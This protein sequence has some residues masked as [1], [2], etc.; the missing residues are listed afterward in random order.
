MSNFES[1][2]I[3]GKNLYIG[4]YL[5]SLNLNVLLQHNITHVLVCGTELSCKF[6]DRITYKHLKIED[7]STYPIKEH[8]EEAYL[9]IFK[10]TQKGRVLVHC[11]Q[12]ISRS[13][14]IVISYFMK[15]QRLKFQK[16]FDV[17][18]KRHPQ[19]KPN[20]GFRKQ[21]IE[22]EKDIGLGGCMNCIF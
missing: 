21:L 16:A 9:F 14:T 7:I 2:K 11:A 12:A 20:Q 6:T 15:A 4:D 17:L 3:V 5:S 19:A 13:V 22:Y 1:L 10:G 8:F 18:K